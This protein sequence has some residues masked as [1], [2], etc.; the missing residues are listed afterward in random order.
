M[1]KSP[2]AIEFP[3]IDA[4]VPPKAWIVSNVGVHIGWYLDRPAID[5]PNTFD[6]L[7]LLLRS[8]PVGAVYIA[9]WPQ[10]ELATRP[11]WAD[12]VSKPGWEARFANATGFGTVIHLRDTVLFLPGTP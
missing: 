9:G 4:K 12:Y 10:G 11:F 7:L 2:R 3:A 5:L 1:E 8:Y 6:E